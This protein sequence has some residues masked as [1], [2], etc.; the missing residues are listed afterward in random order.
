MTNLTFNKALL[1]PSDDEDEIELAVSPADVIE[2]M[3]DDCEGPDE[4]VWKPL[5]HA[6]KLARLACEGIAADG[7]DETTTVAMLKEMS[8][9]AEYGFSPDQRVRDRERPVI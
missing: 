5:I 7:F 1:E 3:I 4:E 6:L 9:L 8:S 2:Q